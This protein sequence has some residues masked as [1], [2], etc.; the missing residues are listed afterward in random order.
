MKTEAIECELF[1]PLSLH[2]GVLQQ[3]FRGRDDAAPACLN[4]EP[5]PPQVLVPQLEDCCVIEDK[6]ATVDWKSHAE[7]D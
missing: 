4:G 7:V 5:P 3:H 2:L 1:A 6:V